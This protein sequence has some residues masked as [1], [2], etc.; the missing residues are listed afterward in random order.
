[1][2][3]EPHRMQRC[4]LRPN[5]VRVK[6]IAQLHGG[7]PGFRTIKNND[8]RSNLL[9][10]DSQPRDCG[11]AFRQSLGIFLIDVQPRRRLFQCNQARRCNYTRLSHPSAEHFP[12]DPRLLDQRFRARNHRS[13][14]SAQ[15]LGQ[16]EHHRIHFS[17][18][19]RDVIS[20]R[21][22]G[23]KNPRPV[24]V[25]FQT[26]GMRMVADVCNLRRRIDRS[27]GQVARVFQ[28]HT[29]GLRIVLDLPLSD[30]LILLPGQHP[31][32]PP[33]HSGHAPCN[34]RHRSQLIQIHV[35]ALFADHFIPMVRPDL[36]RNQV[37]HA[38]RRNKQRRF[39][40]KNLRR[41]LLQAVDR[42]VFSVYVVADL[43]LR[44]RAPHLWRRPRHRVAP[45]VHR[46]R[47]NLP[48]LRNLIRIHPLIP[49][50]HHVAHV[51]LFSANGA[52]P[53]LV[54]VLSVSPAINLS[55]LPISAFLRVLSVSA[56]TF[57]LC[58]GPS[59]LPYF[60]T[61]LVP[62]KP[63][64]KRSV[65]PEQAALQCHL[66]PPNQPTPADQIAPSA[67]PHNPVQSAPHRC[68]PAAATQ[69]TIPPPA[70]SPPS[71]FPAAPPAIVR[72]AR[73]SHNPLFR[74]TSTT[75]PS[76]KTNALPPQLPGTP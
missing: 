49:L 58:F 26:R 53:D 73:Q 27:S 16:T 22:R 62:Q 28:A 56:L 6:R 65:S 2:C 64:S 15:S 48:R 46:S 33:C 3:N 23:V 74:E 24:Q 5:A 30:F 45:Q 66:A 57:I 68:H 72:P 31:V 71:T 67:S 12:V 38:S 40:S 41:T 36:D 63:H 13:N 43:R 14:R 35:A 21:R 60:F 69:E 8:V 34:R 25:H 54:G 20:E 52:H 4:I 50:R 75:A 70:R 37:P 76:P 1:M 32:L 29:R 39:V 18:H 17:R 42:W 11:D 19:L 44:H 59:L 10:I 47:R 55:S 61:S 51:L 7:F 9:R